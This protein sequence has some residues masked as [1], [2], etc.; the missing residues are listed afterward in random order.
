MGMGAAADGLGP[1]D[2]G[3]AGEGLRSRQKRQARRELIDAALALGTAR[4]FHDVTVDEICEQA[5][6]SPRTF[7]RYFG[8]KEALLSAP[9]L[10]LSDQI[11]AA[12]QAAPT[13]L[14]AWRSLRA[15]TAAGCQ[16]IAA[17]PTQFLL[18]GAISA[19]DPSLRSQS[20]VQLLQREPV[21]IDAVARRLPAGAPPGAAMMLAGLVAVALRAAFSTWI[22]QDGRPCL[23]DLVAGRFD[24]LEA[25]PVWLARGST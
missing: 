21:I 22:D 8:T 25:G 15:A 13:E 5:D 14:D 19:R 1:A 20:S 23:A 4:G 18:A 10:D 7:F 9:F 16:W 17:D 24:A 3:P 12:L 6:I 11:L 2:A